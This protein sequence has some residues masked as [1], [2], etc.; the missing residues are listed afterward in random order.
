MLQKGFRKSVRE[1]TSFDYVEVATGKAIACLYGGKTISGASLVPYA[2]WSDTVKTTAEAGIGATKR[3]DVDFDVVVERATII[4]GVMVVNVPLVIESIDSGAQGVKAIVKFRKWDGTT[5]TDLATNTSRTIAAAVGSNVTDVVALDLTIPR[6]TF[7]V[8]DTM[9]L[10]IEIWNTAETGTTTDV[11][12]GHDPKNREL[13]TGVET[14]SQLLC[15]MPLK[16]NT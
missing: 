8:G 11:G 15:L 6:T 5:E 14:P 7:K 2:F 13:Y 3:V 1:L 10:T 12:F 16:V 9:R 4:D